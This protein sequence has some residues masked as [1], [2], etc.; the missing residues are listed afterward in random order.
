MELLTWREGG[1]ASNPLKQVGGRQA[2]GFGILALSVK[3]GRGS[4]SKHAD[5][6]LISEGE[7]DPHG[8]K[9]RADHGG[10][11]RITPYQRAGTIEGNPV[12]S[13]RTA[14][15]AVLGRKS[16]HSPGQRRDPLADL[17]NGGGS[18]GQK[19]RH[20]TVQAGRYVEGR[21]KKTGRSHAPMR[22]LKG[23]SWINTAGRRKKNA[24]DPTAASGGGKGY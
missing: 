2:N 12:P 6:A 22:I 7:K 3:G 14:R 10:K 19:Q 24:S 17:R 8:N 5:P 13:Q 15:S 16:P 9:T 21:S 11:G 23:P 1:T 20:P 4:A 18:G